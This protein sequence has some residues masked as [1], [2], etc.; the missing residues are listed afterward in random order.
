MPS[1]RAFFKFTCQLDETLDNRKL[2]DCK[3]ISLPK[4]SKCT[5]ECESKSNIH[6]KGKGFLK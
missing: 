4:R 2:S 3:I 6:Q 1:N 5:V